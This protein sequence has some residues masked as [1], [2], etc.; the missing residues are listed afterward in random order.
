[1]LTRIAPICVDALRPINGQ[2]VL[3]QYVLAPGVVN[4]SA[5]VS[6]MRSGSSPFS[7]HALH[8][9]DGRQSTA[10]FWAKIYAFLSFRRR[11]P[12][13]ETDSGRAGAG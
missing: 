5:E 10:H 6:G 11:R 7:H 9:H 3:E 2:Q 13:G 1:M 8:S 12:A 4:S